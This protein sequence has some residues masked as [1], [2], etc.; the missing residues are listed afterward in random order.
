MR[1]KLP[2][3]VWSDRKWLACN[4]W[5]CVNESSP[6][7]TKRVTQGVFTVW[8]VNSSSKWTSCWS[9]RLIIRSSNA[10][11]AA[12]W[13]SAQFLSIFFFFTA[14]KSPSALRKQ[15]IHGWKDRELRNVFSAVWHSYNHKKSETFVIFYK[16]VENLKSTYPTFFQVYTAVTNTGKIE[17]TYIF[18]YV[19]FLQPAS[20][21]PENS[22]FSLKV[23]AEPVKE[24]QLC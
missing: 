7:I 11:T 19:T 13:L 2:K 23:T 15:H 21:S 8:A 5:R 16:N 1:T 14:F 3:C 4:K 18:N 12:A 22:Y 6:E 17:F 10:E 9:Q 20:I 24:N